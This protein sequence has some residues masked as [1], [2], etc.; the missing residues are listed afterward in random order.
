MTSE[1][2]VVEPRRQAQLV[3]EITVSVQVLHASTCIHSRLLQKLFTNFPEV[4]E[5]CVIFIFHA[6]DFSRPAPVESPANMAAQALVY[7]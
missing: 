3:L 4:Y 2:I 1:I 7:K 5:S 6:T